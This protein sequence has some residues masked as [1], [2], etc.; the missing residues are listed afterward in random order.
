MAP[1][2]NDQ[3]EKRQ[4]MQLSDDQHDRNWDRVGYGV[5]AFGRDGD[6]ILWQLPSQAAL[7]GRS[8]YLS[9]IQ[10]DMG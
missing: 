1:A 9:I 5:W 7:E 4:K 6:Q 2:R 8:K 3:G 10:W